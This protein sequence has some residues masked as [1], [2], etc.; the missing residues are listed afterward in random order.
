MV[1]K[2]IGICN[3]RKITEPPWSPILSAAIRWKSA[4]WREEFQSGV[5]RTISTFRKRWRRRPTSDRNSRCGLEAHGRG[6]AS[7]ANERT[8]RRS[9]RYQRSFVPLISRMRCAIN[10]LRDAQDHERELEQDSRDENPHEERHDS[11]DQVDYSVRRRT[12]I[13]EHHTSH[14]RDSTKDDA[15]NVQQLYNAASEL[16]LEREVEKARKEV[17]FIGHVAS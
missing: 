10:A 2:W 7:P 3:R 14:D 9:A 11:H 16:V 15:E 6:R 8:G 12:L 5:M 13:T 4:F 17:L 1:L